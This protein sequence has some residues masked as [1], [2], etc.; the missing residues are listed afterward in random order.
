MYDLVVSLAES[1][2]K[3]A[4]SSAGAGVMKLISS[5]VT[6][7][8]PDDLERLQHLVDRISQGNNKKELID[9]LLKVFSKEDEAEAKQALQ[10]TGAVHA[11]NGGIAVGVVGGDLNISR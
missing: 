3:G 2:V 4:G 6:A 11:D 1:L 9:L 7:K 8:R 5:K 10:Q